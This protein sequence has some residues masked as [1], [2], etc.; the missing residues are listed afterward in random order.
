METPSDHAPRPNSNPV[1]SVNMFHFK[2]NTRSCVKKAGTGP[3]LPPLASAFN[4]IL[5][6]LGT[7]QNSCW[8]FGRGRSFHPCLMEDSSCSLYFSRKYISC[9]QH[10]CYPDTAGRRYCGNQV[11]FKKKWQVSNQKIT[12]EVQKSLM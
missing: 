8:T 1:Q 7:E 2:K 3:R 4:N 11:S 9:L 6:H 12:T 5:K 10:V